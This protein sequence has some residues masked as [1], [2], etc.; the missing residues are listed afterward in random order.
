MDDYRYLTVKAFLTP[1]F[2][3]VFRSLDGRLQVSHRK[4]LPHVIYCR[5][6]RWP[7]LNSHQE[8]RAI[9]RCEYAFI[10][11][12]DEVCVNPFH[13][14]RVEPPGESKFYFIFFFFWVV[15]FQRILVF[16]RFTTPG[17]T[18][19]LGGFLENFSFCPFHYTRV[20]PPGEREFGG[21]GGGICLENFSFC[22]FHYTRVEPPGQSEFLF[23]CFLFLL[24]LGGFYFFENFSF[25]LFH[26]TRVEPPGES[27]FLCFLFLLFL[28][29]FYLEKFK[30]PG[31][32]KFQCSCFL[33]CYFWVG[34]IQRIFVFV[35][36]F[37]FNLF[38]YTR[39]EPP[40]ETEF[41]CCCFFVFV[42]FGW[43][44]FR[45]FQFLSVSLHEG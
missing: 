23:C 42:V 3:C 6:W 24:F 25:C 39:V 20:E 34:F 44:L 11:K 26:Y 37:S 32:S 8:L 43:V 10:L 1:V 29:G 14:T 12:K 18:E 19:F 40:G 31:E 4:G 28:G 7:D 2:T 27:E 41:Q 38:H 15:F 16:V 5:L 9:D 33:F 17:E 13:Y 45:E 36:S 21:G 22:L 35:P 30:P